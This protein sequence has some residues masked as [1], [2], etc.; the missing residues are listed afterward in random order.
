VVNFNTDIKIKPLQGPKMEMVKILSGHFRD[1]FEA[2]KSQK[3]TSRA[4]N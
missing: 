4:L 3:P 2:Q 1:C